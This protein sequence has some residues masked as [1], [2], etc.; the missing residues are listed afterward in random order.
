MVTEEKTEET[1]DSLYEEKFE[2]S[3]EVVE[4]TEELTPSEAVEET[5]NVPQ[6]I[7]QPTEEAKTDKVDDTS[8]EVKPSEEP[9]Y[10]EL[11]EKFEH[12]VKSQEGRLK[13][14]IKR[15]QDSES[16]R[17]QELEQKLKSFENEKRLS[18]YDEVDRNEIEK[19]QKENP[20]LALL[21]IGNSSKGEYW[22]KILLNRG[23]EELEV[24]YNI[25]VNE[26]PEVE[27]IKQ[28][29]EMEDRNRFNKAIEEVH[30]DWREITLNPEPENE[31]DGYNRDFV[32][33][34]GSLPRNIAEEAA[35]RILPGTPQ[36]RGGT[37]E[38][39]N[40]VISAYK[41]HL[42]HMQSQRV[43]DN[44]TNSSNVASNNTINSDAKQIT[45]VKRSG[46]SE[47]NTNTKRS[48]L[49]FDELYERK[50]GNKK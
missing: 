21:T 25:S 50:Y 41:L 38:E 17:I 35:R 19:F 10:K 11:Y 18:R 37:P 43:N 42:Q 24:L 8:P 5:E 9:N 12:K 14:E 3:N 27:Q 49:T 39:I 13:A 7:E 16:K 47:P 20:E 33:W 26:N 34:I 44:R 1:F 36:R 31:N 40:E 48:N 32:A 46:N 30:P 15:I 29:L 22:E 45:A 2:K 28:R 23:A 4:T 6:E